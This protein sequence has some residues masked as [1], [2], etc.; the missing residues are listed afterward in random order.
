MNEIIRIPNIEKY[1]ME[2]LN[3]ELILT[4]K[5]QY[6]NHEQKAFEQETLQKSEPKSAPVP[7]LGSRLTKIYDKL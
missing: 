2:I 6:I 1:T 7:K 3:G 5:K 4:P